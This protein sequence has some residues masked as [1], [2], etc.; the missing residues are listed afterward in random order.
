MSADADSHYLRWIRQSSGKQREIHIPSDAL[1]LIQHRIRQRLLATLPLPNFVNG[2]VKGR[3][4]LSNALAHIEK[5]NVASIDVKDC[6]PSITHHMVYSFWRRLSFGPSLASMLTKLT[7]HAGHLPQGTPTS[8]ILANL[9]LAPTDAVIDAVA[10]DLDLTPT[11][12]LDDI[13]LSGPRAHEAI[14]RIVRALRQQGL[15]VRHRKTYCVG[16][17]DAHLVTG[18]NVNGSYPSVPKRHRAKVR[19][20]VHRLITARQNSESTAHIEESVIGHLEYLRRT[21]PGTVVRLERKLAEAGIVFG[22]KGIRKPGATKGS[23]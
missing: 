23:A 19:A 5:S 10:K 13:D 18:Y 6:F 11:R 4:A 12:Y 2:C 21:N 7:T 14:P 9:I 16:P 3:S 17:R 8:D 1:K 15:A 22:R 20:V